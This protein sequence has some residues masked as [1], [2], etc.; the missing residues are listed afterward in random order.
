M[1]EF[2]VHLG[3]WNYAKLVAPKEAA[4]I[5]PLIAHLFAQ[6]ELAFSDFAFTMRLGASTP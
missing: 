4:L 6:N 3:L 5:V 1:Y 2:S